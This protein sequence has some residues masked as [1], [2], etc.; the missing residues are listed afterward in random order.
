MDRKVVVITLDPGVTIEGIGA[1]SIC[2]RVEQRDAP[3]LG[4]GTE[5]VL[6]NRKSDV[7]DPVHAPGEAA[8]AQL[9]SDTGGGAPRR[10]QMDVRHARTVHSGATICPIGQRKEIP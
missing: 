2:E 8:E 9:G 5:D 6:G 3:G 1:E 7:L 4:V 10:L